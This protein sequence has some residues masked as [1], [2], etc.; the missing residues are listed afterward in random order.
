MVSRPPRSN[1]V[2]QL[3]SICYTPATLERRPAD[4][5][6]RAA[7][8]QANLL[9]D[10][11]IEGDVKSRGGKR[12]LNFFCAEMVEQLKKEGFRTGPGELGEQLVIAGLSPESLTVGV[13]LRLGESAVI[14]ITTPRT[15]C[16][17]FA[18]IQ[19]KTIEQAWGRLGFMA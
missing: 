11:G 1:P 3:I 8:G 18:H 14:E 10:H 5:Y 13:R 15:P 17:R 2:A 12:Q 16:S 7:F 19:G 6:A 9:A 4:D